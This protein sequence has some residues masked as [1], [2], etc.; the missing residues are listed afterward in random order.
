MC[1]NMRTTP[2]LFTVIQLNKNQVVGRILKLKRYKV[3]KI[4]LMKVFESRLDRQSVQEW[5]K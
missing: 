2:V 3:P 4:V 5:T 1:K